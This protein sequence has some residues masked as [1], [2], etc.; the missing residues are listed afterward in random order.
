MIGNLFI[1]GLI[2]SLRNLRDFNTLN[3]SSYRLQGISP[4]LCK[5]K[6]FQGLKIKGDKTKSFIDLTGLET[7]IQA[8]CSDLAEFSD[9]LRIDKSFRRLDI[10]CDLVAFLEVLCEQK[11]ANLVTLDVSHRDFAEFPQVLCKLKSLKA[12]DIEWNNKIQKLPETLANLTNLEKLDVSNCD[13]TTFSQVLCELESLKVLDIRCNNKINKLPETLVDLTKLEVI[14]LSLCSLT[15]FPH[16]LCKLKSLTSLD[17]SGNNIQKLPGTLEYLVNLEILNVS[18]CGFTEFPDVLCKLILLKVLI[19]GG[20]D[21]IQ[22]IPQTLSNLT[23]LETFDMPSCDLMDFPLVL[24]ELISLKMLSIGDNKKVQ[25]LPESIKFLTNIQKLD[26][27]GTSISQLPREI[28]HCQNLKK[29][30]ISGCKFKEFPTVIFYMNTSLN[31]DAFNLSIT[32]LD[33]EFV[34]LWVQ[35]PDI[36]GEGKFQ[37]V[38]GLLPINIV[39]PPHEIVDRGPGACKKYYRALESDEAVNCSMLNVTVIGKTGTGKSSLIHSMN[40]GHSVPIRPSEKTIPVDTFRMKCKDVCLKFIDLRR[41]DI[42]GMTCRLFLKSTRQETIIVVKL[43]EYS[44]SS[45]N[46]HV[47]KWLET[48]VSHMKSG[49]ICI[50]A[51]QCDL[52]CKEEVKAKMSIMKEKVQKWIEKELSF[53]RKMKLRPLTEVQETILV[54]RNIPYFQTSSKNMDG[55]K[56]LKEYLFHQAKHTKLTLPRYWAD[57]YMRIAELTDKGT[58]FMTED[59]YQNL[60]EE[61]KPIYK[62]SFTNGKESL[63]CLQFLHDT[64]MILWYGGK[65][66]NLRKVIFPDLS[67]PVRLIQ[68]LFRHDLVEVLNEYDHEIFSKYFTSKSEFKDHVK[69]FSRTGNLNEALLQC[70]WKKFEF[71]QEVFD[72]MVE[73]LTMLDLCYIDEQGSENMLRLPWFVR[74]ENM[75]FLNDL[76]PDKLPPDT[77][78]CTFIYFFPHRIPSVIYEKF[79]ARL[80]RHVET[81]A[82]TREDRK[83]LVY[84]QQNRVKILFERNIEKCSPFMKTRLRCFIDDL[85]ELKELSLSLQQDMSDLCDEYQ[86]LDVDPL[87]L[88][89]HCLLTGSSKPTERLITDIAK[90]QKQSLKW[91]PCNPHDIESVQIPALLIYL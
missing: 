90:C 25:S 64:G 6:Y 3:I 24:C 76:W 34:E 13:L 12:L 71:S 33:K 8:S 4:A 65:Y 67:F 85:L 61:A 69:S 63:Q 47:T 56:E 73:M 82:H 60:F 23:N 18:S 43:P 86:G 9:A 78:E 32:E 62:R 87:F 38:T 68:Y 75:S 77:L 30:D 20:N 28:E 52:C 79:C 29:L 74:E 31:V 50:V 26:V 7:P 54:D 83:N 48:A 59:Q 17:I 40:K 49:K 10:K 27:S 39:K 88:C 16:V 53:F 5:L 58:Q 51:T 41:H 66:E 55:I 14:N 15:E 70:I 11:L 42:Y 21:K 89:P 84:I 57:I 2:D 45:H 91:I 46:D 72:T 35:N 44:E 22:K 80:H 81:G 37:K 19:I 36:F 1:E